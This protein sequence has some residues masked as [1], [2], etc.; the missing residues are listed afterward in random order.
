M[1]RHAAPR[2]LPS[3]RTERRSGMSTDHAGAHGRI[4]VL[5]IGPFLAGERGALAELARHVARSCQDTGFLVLANHG[6]PA[7]LSEGCFQAATDVFA[8]P[9]EQK[10][11]LKV[12]DINVGYLPQGAQVIRTS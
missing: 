1:P 11:A 4:P 2:G 10:L 5:D 7:A 8:L 3:A 6:V 9:M 12:G